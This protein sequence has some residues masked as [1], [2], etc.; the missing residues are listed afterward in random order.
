[1]VFF[2][3]NF[4]EDSSDGQGPIGEQDAWTATLTTKKVGIMIFKVTF[5]L[6]IDRVCIAITA[7]LTTKKV[8]IIFFKVAFKFLI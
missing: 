1:M 7:T 4:F 6:G 3:K 2:Q 5:C 8:G